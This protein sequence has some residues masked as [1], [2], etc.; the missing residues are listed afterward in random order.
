[1]QVFPYF[2]KHTADPDIHHLHE[3]CP[4]GRQIPREHLR[5]GSRGWPLCELCAE[6]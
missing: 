5:Q 4:V 1:M 2:S 3:D 6:R